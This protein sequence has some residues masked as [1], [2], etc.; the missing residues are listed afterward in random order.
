MLIGRKIWK[1]SNEYSKP[2]SQG[3]RKGRAKIN[4]EQG[5]NKEEIEVN[6]IE[7]RKMMNLKNGSLIKKT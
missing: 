4:P 6:V 2:P 7:N 1:V 5:N 3:T